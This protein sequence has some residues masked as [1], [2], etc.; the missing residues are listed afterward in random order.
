MRHWSEVPEA[1]RRWHRQ[2]M[3]AHNDASKVVFTQRHLHMAAQVEKTFERD[4]LFKFQLFQKNPP[5]WRCVHIYSVSSHLLKWKT[6]YKVPMTD[7]KQT[8]VYEFT[9]KLPLHSVATQDKIT[10][11]RNQ[12]T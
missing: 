3:T 4:F 7:T 2:P 10:M 6:E 11:K 12:S 5:M 8:S 9:S 1:A